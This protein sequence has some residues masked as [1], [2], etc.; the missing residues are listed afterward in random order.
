MRIAIAVAVG[1]ILGTV[2]TVALERQLG[3][4]KRAML[5]PLPTASAQQEH[6]FELSRSKIICDRA[7]L[8]FDAADYAYCQEPPK[9]PRVTT[10]LFTPAELQKNH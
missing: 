2:G 9:E 1:I 3:L 4:D 7:H 10:R 6:P 8:A 5:L